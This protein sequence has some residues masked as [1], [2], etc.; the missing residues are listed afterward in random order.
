MHHKTHGAIGYAD[1]LE[2]R[3][4]APIENSPDFMM[5]VNINIHAQIDID[6]KKKLDDSAFFRTQ[7]YITEICYSEYLLSFGLQKKTFFSPAK[8][9]KYKT[10]ITFLPP[11]LE[12]FL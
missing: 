12:F 2:T 10:L 6:F 11:T 5:T 7:S 3:H 1:D 4:L 8:T 9:L